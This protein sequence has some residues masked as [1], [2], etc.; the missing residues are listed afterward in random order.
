MLRNATALAVLLSSSFLLAACS[1]T[2]VT[3]ASIAPS[4]EINAKSVIPETASFSFDSD[5][6]ATDLSFQCNVKTYR[7]SMNDTLRQTV[8]NAVKSGFGSLTDSASPPSPYNVKF[9][10]ID[11]DTHTAITGASSWAQLVRVYL[12]LNGKVI[13]RDAKGN[14]IQKFSVSSTGNSSNQDNCYKLKPLIQDAQQKA[15]KRIG[16]E[17]EDKLFNSNILNVN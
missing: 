17:I 9:E 4:R 5:A 10:L 6:A 3:V 8:R 11:A 12:T 1:E 13:V 2:V 15:Y 7:Y 16:E 14:L